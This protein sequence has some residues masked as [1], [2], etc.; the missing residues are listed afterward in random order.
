SLDPE[1]GKIYVPLGSASPNFNAST[2]QTPNYYS[3][4][5]MAINVTNGKILWATPFIGHGT[6]LDVSVPDTHDWDTS[7]GSSISRVT[8]DNIQK[9][10]VIRH[11]KMGNVIA[12]DAA[13]GEEIGWK[14]LAKR[15]NTE[16][17]PSPTGSGMIWDYGVYNYHAVDS[18]TLYIAATNRGLN[19]FTDGLSG[20]KIPPPRTIEQG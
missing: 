20:H 14:V 7:W 13:T 18:N 10:L 19:F 4:H 8:I 1:T 11:D 15:N 17:I 5:M 12:M 3:H 9:K 16:S 2:R 6:V